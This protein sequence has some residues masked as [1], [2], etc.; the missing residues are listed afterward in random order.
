M[1]GADFKDDADA[2]QFALN[3]QNYNE[4][5]FFKHENRTRQIVS[6]LLE[7]TLEQFKKDRHQLEKLLS[8]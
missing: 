7:P 2:K 1:L 6:K 5:D 3:I 8:L 4:I